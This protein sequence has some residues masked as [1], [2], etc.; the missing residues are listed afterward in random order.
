MEPQEPPP[1]NPP[2]AQPFVTI[3]ASINKLET[4]CVNENW[5]LEHMKKF[6]Q[7]KRTFS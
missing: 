2:L 1:T 6:G 4:E 5:K 7:K 3:N